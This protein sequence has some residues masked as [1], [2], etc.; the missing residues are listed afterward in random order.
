MNIEQINRMA[1]AYARHTKLKRS[2]L[3]VHIVNDGKFFPRLDDGGQCTVRTAERVAQWFANNWPEDL[4]WPAD[5][6]RP[7]KS[8]PKRRVA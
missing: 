5:I 7:P 6:P 8:K 1:N 4:E 3:G 2:T